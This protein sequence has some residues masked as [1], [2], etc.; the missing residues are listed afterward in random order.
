VFACKR[1][2]DEKFLR[3]MYLRLH[4]DQ[5]VRKHMLSEH[6]NRYA[7]L[8]ESAVGPKQAESLLL[9]CCWRTNRHPCMGRS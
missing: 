1:R 8:D 9:R 3:T 7:L 5:F 2:N 4:G 6:G